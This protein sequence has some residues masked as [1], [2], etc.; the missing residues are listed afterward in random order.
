MRLIQAAQV[1]LR[2][3][4]EC[5]SGTGPHPDGRFDDR[6]VSVLQIALLS[7]LPAPHAHEVV[8]EPADA[9]EIRREVKGGRR[10]HRVDVL[11]TM[12]N[13]GAREIDGS[14]APIGE[15]AR[16]RGEDPQRRGDTR[17]IEPSAILI[18]TGGR[19]WTTPRGRSWVT[20]RGGAWITTRGRRFGLA[21]ADGRGFDGCSVSR[22][23]SARSRRGRP[24]A[25][26]SACGL[27]S[28]SRLG[29]GY[30]YGSGPLFLSPPG[31]IGQ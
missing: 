6:K 21:T 24:W 26:G 7:G 13:V 5:H 16:I 25:L 1:E 3:S 22:A 2:P 8:A 4:V 14:A 17:A 12:V 29:Y 19:S 20:T 28:A 31:G 10:I 9:V 27:G 11:K 15:V 23:V 18:T 30:G